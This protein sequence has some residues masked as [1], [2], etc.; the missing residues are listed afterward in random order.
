MG[1]NQTF[2]GLLEVYL[3]SFEFS[4]DFIHYLNE[5]LSNNKIITI[6]LK[7]EGKYS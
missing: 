1:A 2:T 4:S 7:H 3:K 6:L 5:K